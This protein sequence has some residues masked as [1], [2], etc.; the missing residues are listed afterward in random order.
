MQRQRDSSTDHWKKG[1]KTMSMMCR[2]EGC[3]QKHGMCRH[4]RM[5]L[6]MAMLI[7]AGAA[8]WLLA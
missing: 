3:T 8:Y 4:E 1:G 5:M 2:M 6:V 7:I